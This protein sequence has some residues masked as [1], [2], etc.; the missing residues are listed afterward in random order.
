LSIAGLQAAIAVS[1]AVSNARSR[2]RKIGPLPF[3][4]AYFVDAKFDSTIG[5]FI[6]ERSVPQRVFSSVAEGAGAA[7]PALAWMWVEALRQSSMPVAVFS[8]AVTELFACGTHVFGET[9]R[10]PTRQSLRCSAVGRDRRRR[11]YAR[12]STILTAYSAKLPRN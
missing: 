8:L 10:M 12:R 11:M 1:P 3:T 7:P 6:R 4:L 5:V 9:Y 2:L